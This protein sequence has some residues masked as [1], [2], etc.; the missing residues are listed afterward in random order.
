MQMSVGSCN[1]YLLRLLCGE[2]QARSRGEAVTEQREIRFHS[3]DDGAA[4]QKA[5][6]GLLRARRAPDVY[7][8]LA[9]R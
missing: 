4:G 8:N 6:G 9:F 5:G 2:Q 3:S 1:R 7:K